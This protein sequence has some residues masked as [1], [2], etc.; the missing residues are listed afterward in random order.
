MPGVRDDPRGAGRLGGKN[1][2]RR[3]NASL[4]RLRA[5]DDA[6]LRYED[7]VA[8]ADHRKGQGI[9]EDALCAAVLVDGA[10]GV[11]DVDD[12]RIRAARGHFLA[13]REMRA[14]AEGAPMGVEE[15]SSRF[16]AIGI[17]GEEGRPLPLVADGPNTE[18]GDDGGD[19]VEEN[20]A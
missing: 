1:R 18:E 12:V 19:E 13:Q 2:Q 8:R 6:G 9:D 17:G 14:A 10:A 5:L 11:G 20:D 3:V 15:R 4:E 16:A 7:I